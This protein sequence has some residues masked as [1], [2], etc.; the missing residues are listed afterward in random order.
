MIYEIELGIHLQSEP[1]SLDCTYPAETFNPIDV[2][3]L[4]PKPDR[5]LYSSESGVVR[6][7]WDDSVP[8]AVDMW[9]AQ[10][11]EGTRTWQFYSLA[12]QFSQVMLTQDG[13]FQTRPRQPTAM[14]T[15]VFVATTAEAAK[16]GVGVEVSTNRLIA[17]A[18]Q[19]L[20]RERD[21][22][23]TESAIDITAYPLWTREASY[24]TTTGAG[25]PTSAGTNALSQIVEGALRDVLG[26]KP[27]AQ[28]PDAFISA[29]NQAFTSN[30]VEGHTEWTWTPKSYAVQTDMGAVTGAQASL[31]NRAK[32]ALDQCLP[33]LDGLRSL[34]ADILPDNLNSMREVVRSQVTELVHE[35]GLLGGPRSQR[36][37]RLFELLLGQGGKSNPED[38]GGSLSVLRYRFGL[39]RNRVNSIEDEQNLT[40]YLILVD[41][42]IGL[43]HSWVNQQGAM[44]H[45][46]FLGTQ[47]V[48]VSRTLDVVAEQVDDT[49]AAMDTVFLGAAERASISLTFGDE[50]HLFLGDLFDWITHIAKDEGPSLI[51]NSGKDGIVTLTAILDQLQSLTLGALLTPEGKQKPKDMPP[52]YRTPRVQRSLQALASQLRKAYDYAN[53]IEK[54]SL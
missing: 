26:W 53:Y 12:D 38:V 45:E 7:I 24:P 40:N 37:D 52:A 30:D 18:E 10:Y 51:K 19:A 27:S 21:T 17:D 25:F 41:Y 4:D 14:Y 54:P 36:V 15:I 48:L 5:A 8:E 49:V 23:L 29:L 44:G 50:R 39:N 9:F 13:K 32:V 43:H 46:P 11:T 31:Y 20:R 47:L 3:K 28:K 6:L 1:D 33:L 22:I 16:A 35:F 2:F 42:V 34:R